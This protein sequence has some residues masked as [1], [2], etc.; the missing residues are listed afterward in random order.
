MATQ[1][2]LCFTTQNMNVCYVYIPNGSTDNSLVTTGPIGTILGA[3]ARLGAPIVGGLVGNAFGI[4][5]QISAGASA[6]IG[7]VLGTILS[8]F[9]L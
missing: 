3:A 6:P 2:Q 5:P 7:Q 8:F 1:Q 9:P 4:N